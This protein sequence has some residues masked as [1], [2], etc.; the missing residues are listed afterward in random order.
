MNADPQRSDDDWP[1]EEF[2]IRRPPRPP[3]PSPEWIYFGSNLSGVGAVGGAIALVACLVYPLV[4]ILALLLFLGSV[5]LQSVG[6]VILAWNN[7]GRRAA[8]R[9]FLL[10]ALVVLGTLPIYVPHY[11]PREKGWH[12]HPIW[13]VGHVH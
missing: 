4:E 5:L 13:A 10:L 7:E 11:I 2:E 9:G 6:I 1:T 3:A 12:R 8:R